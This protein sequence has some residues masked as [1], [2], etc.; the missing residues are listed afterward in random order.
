MPGF[1]R[2]EKKAGGGAAVARRPRL[3][4]GSRRVTVSAAAVLPGPRP[5]RRHRPRRGPAFPAPVVLR[6]CRSAP[7]PSWWQHGPQRLTSQ[8]FASAGAAFSA[9]RSAVPAEARPCRGSL[10]QVADGGEGFL[11]VVP[12]Q[13]L[14]AL[15]EVGGLDRLGRRRGP[16][17]SWRRPRSRRCCQSLPRQA[18]CHRGR[19]R[20]RSRPAVWPLR[21]A[22]SLPVAMSHT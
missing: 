19:K 20:R 21:A 3:G 15:F 14:P 11:G 4:V 17:R 6:R 2:S 5:S 8:R 16:V 10:G 22:S 13:G 1:S 9:G 18:S 7:A 12:G